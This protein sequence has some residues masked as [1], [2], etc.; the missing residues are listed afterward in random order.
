MTT[1]HSHLKMGLRGQLVLLFI[2]VS[3]IPLLVISLMTR[4]LGVNALKNT[5]GE[6]LAQLAKEKLDQADQSVATRLEAIQNGLESIGK[7]VA[8]TARHSND[9]IKL[10]TASGQLEDNLRQ[11]EDYAGQG[12]R[13]I[14]TNSHGQVIRATGRDGIP[15]F[16]KI[17]EDWWYKAYNNDW[18]YKAYNNGFG[19]YLIEDIQYD[20]KRQL[21]YLPIAIPIRHETEVVGVLR[22]EVTLPELSE[23]IKQPVGEDRVGRK[24]ESF[25][26]SEHGQV[27]ASDPASGYGFEERIE[28]SV[29][30]MEGVINADGV[31]Y[32]Y[33]ME[34][35]SD[36]TGEKKVYGWARTR[37]WTE[38]K[39]K[40]TQNFVNWTVL[41]LQ[42][43][44]V[45]FQEISALTKKVLTFT[46]ISCIVIM[47]IAWI[48]S[49]R[50]VKPIMR[51]TQGAKAIGRGEFDQVIRVESSNEVGILAE[52]FNAMRANL[53]DAIGK[54]TEEEKKM[55]AIVNSLAE[56]L[57]L[58][59]GDN[60][61]LH[62]NPTAESLLDVSGGQTGVDFTQI[63]RDEELTTALKESQRQIAL[64]KA[65]ISEV[66]LDRDDGKLVLRVVASPF[67]DESGAMLG[68]VYV[69]DDITREKEIDQM[70]SDLISLVNH[71][72]RTPLTSIIG[73]V[74]FMSDGKAGMVNE[75]QKNILA[76]VERQS[77]QLTALINDM[78]DISRIEAGR[79][80]MDQ[81]PVSMLEVAIQRIEE[82]LPQADAKSI[83][84]QLS[85]PESLPTL[86]GDEAR[87]GQ[88]FTNLIGNAIKF[89]PDNGKITVKLQADG[90]LLHVEIVDTGPGIPIEERN[91]IFDKF[92]Q[93]SDFRTRQQGGS[94]LGLS[95][96]KHIIEAH[97][98][99]L[100]VDDGD[101]GIG[102][103]FQ[104]VLPL[105]MNADSSEVIDG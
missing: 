101:D 64:N 93:L 102:S 73:F 105:K 56:G 42:P 92:Y 20:V 72:L 81:K 14:I 84:L 22:A 6:S 50:I 61:V 39:W 79:I 47:P 11:L 54:I 76:R 2:V 59:D 40:G 99:K 8:F 51:V 41:V 80:Q 89:T 10:F 86:I 45:A 68:T 48:V 27:I 100:W 15:Y 82:I 104:F 3:L 37:R 103:N 19:F 96:V 66:T 7:T 75:K 24:I 70:K 83:R 5:I 58:V 77:K 67:L 44:T 33:E 62:I 28:M 57:I 35:E 63:I 36:T 46:L 69:F 9:K 97:A 52:E 88:V 90:H 94:G 32:G 31:H 21:H 43:A 25:I 55:T 29:A 34:G 18:W 4:A 65:D 78:L 12:S 13:I 95:I 53:K 85:A 38:Q 49:Q 60:Q 30:V 23:L 26:L 98:G 91:T 71:E 1:E 16:P 74:S 87:L 17:D